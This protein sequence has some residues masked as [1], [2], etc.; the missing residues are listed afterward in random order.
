MESTKP[1]FIPSVIF[2]IFQNNE[3]NENENIGYL[4]NTPFIFDRCH[5]SWAAETPDKYEC[6]VTDLTNT[7]NRLKFIIKETLMNG[8]L[9]TPNTGVWVTK[10]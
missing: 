1:I 6:D 9:V 3:N 4:W 10:S 2:L 8:G 5:H 7:F